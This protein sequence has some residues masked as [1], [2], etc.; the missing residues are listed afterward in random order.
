MNGVEQI[1]DDEFQGIIGIPLRDGAGI[2][3][4]WE[5]FFRGQQ[6]QK[7][8][9]IVG[10]ILIVL[11]GVALLWIFLTEQPP[12]LYV[13]PG[14]GVLL[15]L[16]VGL[17]LQAL[18]KSGRARLNLLKP[19]RLEQASQA[20]AQ[21]ISGLSVQVS[22]YNDLVNQLQ[23][24]KTGISWREFRKLSDDQR[25]FIQSSFMRVRGKLL[26]SLRVCRQ[27]IE[28]PGQPVGSWDKEI[29]SRDLELKFRFALNTMTSEYYLDIIHA[30]ENVEEEVRKQIER[31]SP[32]S[33]TMESPKA[34]KV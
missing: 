30:L 8:L 29:I 6:Q 21:A 13:L 25:L 3:D 1:Q 16:L 26:G 23:D 12:W 15:L 27:Q 32:S 9:R 28:H 24:S 19:G 17:R 20:L 33:P 11:I 2:Y 5:S 14:V 34:A 18:I 4:V 22:R 31:L 10:G 7:G